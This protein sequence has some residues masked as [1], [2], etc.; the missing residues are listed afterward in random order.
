[1]WRIALALISL[2]AFITVACGESRGGAPAASPTEQTVAPPTDTPSAGATPTQAP[3]GHPALAN[4]P[5][6]QQIPTYDGSGQATH[7]DI[8][9]FPD[10][11]HGHKYW[12]A[13]TPYTYDSAGR[14]N[15]SIVVSNDGASWVVP[16][17]L[18]NPLVP[19]PA[20]D[21]NSDPDIVYDPRHDELYLYYTEL[22][23]AEY[24]SSVNEN[25]LRLLKSPDGV[26]WSDPQTVMSWDLG[27]DPIYVSPA[28][29]YR[30]G[31]FEMWMAGDSGVVHATSEDGVNWSALQTAGIDA[32]VWH[33]NVDYVE[34]ESQYWM[35]FVDSPLAGSRLRLATSEDGLTW[36]VYPAPLLAPGSGWD[37]ERIYRAVFLYDEGRLRVWY[38]A[39]SSAGEW[40][41]GYSEAAL[42]SLGGD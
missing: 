24:C 25:H 15:P 16:P 27:K 40:H 20:C 23:R 39:R 30:R 12:M 37:D 36:D 33:L 14:E 7:P 13:M 6:F 29:I 26:H 35:L 31:S 2:V 11:W 21:H 19:P 17:G 42:G 10:G 34:G 1:M 38:S 3:T 32:T 41:V 4:A 8:A 18:T 5:S 22:E 28:V 9:Y